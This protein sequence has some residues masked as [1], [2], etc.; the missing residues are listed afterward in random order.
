MVMELF[1]AL[2]TEFAKLSKHDQD[3]KK[4]VFS[5]VFGKSYQTAD[6]ST[7]LRHNVNLLLGHT[8]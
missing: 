4:D 2:D 6:L 7:A 3:G 8:R 1:T 5:R